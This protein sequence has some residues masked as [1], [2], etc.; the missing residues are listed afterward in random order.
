MQ[1]LKGNKESDMRRNKVIFATMVL[2]LG[3]A[4]VGAAPADARDSNVYKKNGAA[5]QPSKVGAK[6]ATD[7]NLVIWASSM[8]VVLRYDA[9][10]NTLIASA[11][12]AE[13][14]ALWYDPA[15]IVVGNTISARADLS[16]G[17]PAAWVD[18]LF[19]DIVIRGGTA[20]VY[21]STSDDPV[22]FLY[23]GRAAKL[24]TFF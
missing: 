12:D 21:E 14:P 7:W 20:Y 15:P 24:V 10:A 18:S 23:R 4:L 22:V 5:A 9:E 13:G 8:W 2:V 19:Y 16:L 11:S 17:D 1:R 6:L 3:V